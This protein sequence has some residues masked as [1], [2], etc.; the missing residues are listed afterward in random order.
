M[1][2]K[3]LNRIWNWLKRGHAFIPRLFFGID[4]YHIKKE[5]EPVGQRI[6]PWMECGCPACGRSVK[7]FEPCDCDEMDEET[8]DKAFKESL[9]KG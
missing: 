1:K 2:T 3:I 6:M 7:A 5:K 4:H 9:S 8:L